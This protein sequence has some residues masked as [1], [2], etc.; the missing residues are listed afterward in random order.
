MTKDPTHDDML[1]FL[2][3]CQTYDD[4]DDMEFEIE[5]AIYWF[6]NDYHGGQDS[7]LYEALSSSPYS[8]GLIRSGPVDDYLYNC[9]IEEYSGE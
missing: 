4:I 7:N 1:T 5:E 3:Q 9:L 8:P 6:A 2:K